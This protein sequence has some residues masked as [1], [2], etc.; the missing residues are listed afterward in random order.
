MLIIHLSLTTNNLER[1]VWQEFL[2]PRPRRSNLCK[3]RAIS[4]NQKLGPQTLCLAFSGDGTKYMG[5]KMLVK[6]H[7]WGIQ[8]NFMKGVTS[9]EGL[10]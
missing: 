6:V 5:V 9:G 4:W 3:N 8:R 7:L 10:G 2:S 1:Q